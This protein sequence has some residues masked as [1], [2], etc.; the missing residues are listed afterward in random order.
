MGRLTRIVL[1]ATATALAGGLTA[2]GSSEPEPGTGSTAAPADLGPAVTAPAEPAAGPVTDPDAL[3]AALLT[4]DDL[5]IGFVALPG[6]DRQDADA[7]GAGVTQPTTNPT[8][9]ANVL[10]TIARQARGSSADA[11][12]NFSGPDFT[13]IDID[14]ASF[15][16]N[17]AAEAFSTV[18]ATLR[19]CTAYTGTDGDEIAVDYRIEPLAMP[20]VGDASTAIRLVTTSDGFSLLSDAVVAVVDSTVV[21]VVATGPEPIDRGVLE[22]LARSSAERIRAAAPAN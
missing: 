4:A 22:A 20:T 16:E 5:P 10:D 12:S 19:E 18:Q 8:R 2:C 17:G 1:A 7:D 14:A 21:Q 6:V 15:P 11:E 13:S 3:H 9:C